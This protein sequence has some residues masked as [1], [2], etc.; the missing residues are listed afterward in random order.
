[1]YE[2]YFRR[3]GVVEHYFIL[4][5]GI[6]LVVVV[7]IAG[8]RVSA[9]LFCTNAIAK[10]NNEVQHIK[11]IIRRVYAGAEGNID[12]YDLIVPRGSTYCFLNGFIYI[13]NDCVADGFEVEHLLVYNTLISDRLRLSP[14]RIPIIFKNNELDVAAATGALCLRPGS[15]SL[16][17]E[18]T[19]SQVNLIYIYGTTYEVE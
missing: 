14:D 9:D 13:E 17:F 2:F 1:M 4:I 12:T 10:A 6:L 16:R 18:R 5:L 7:F 15:Y 11:E 8:L 19:F 3:R